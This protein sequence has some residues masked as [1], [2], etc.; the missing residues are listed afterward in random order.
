MI[1]SIPQKVIIDEVYTRQFVCI[2]T[3]AQQSI[4]FNL[5]IF[6]ISHTKQ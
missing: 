2:D 4:F 6:I 3:W 5:L 1:Q